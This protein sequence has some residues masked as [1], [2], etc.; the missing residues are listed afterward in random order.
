MI[1]KLA[2]FYVRW[3]RMLC[4]DTG[5]LTRVAVHTCA[6]ASVH[7]S[8][9]AE[10]RRR[11]GPENTRERRR[12]R[13]RGRARARRARPRFDPQKPDLGEKLKKR[14]KSAVGALRGIHRDTAGVWAAR[15][16]LRGALTEDLIQNVAFFH[17][18]RER[19][20]RARARIWVRAP[21]PAAAEACLG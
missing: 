11:S 15:R 16:R 6:R 4:F 20:A 1:P 3:V 2:D 9:E 5:V 12:T 7:V 17:S 19:R 14:M 10:Q 21:P 8:R 13:A 18:L